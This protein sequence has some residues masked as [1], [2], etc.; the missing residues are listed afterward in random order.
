MK[1]TI[2]YKIEVDEKIKLWNAYKGDEI[3]FFN[4]IKKRM[5]KGMDINPDDIMK[6]EGKEKLENGI[7]Y[8]IYTEIK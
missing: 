8:I 2:E 6:I 3:R 4:E 5:F 1:K 7:K